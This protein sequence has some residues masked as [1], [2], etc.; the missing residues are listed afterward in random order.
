VAGIIW[1]SLPFPTNSGV[2]ENPSA[3]CATLLPW[4]STTSL[5]LSFIPIS[6]VIL[7]LSTP[8]TWWPVWSLKVTDTTTV[9]FARGPMVRGLLSSTFPINV[10]AFGGIRW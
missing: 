4:S 7:V 10:S 8:V 9:L 1:L 3:V 5:R 2:T 6:I